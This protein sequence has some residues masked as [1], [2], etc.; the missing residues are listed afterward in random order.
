V[1]YKDSFHALKVLTNLKNWL[2][3][4]G[5]RKLAANVDLFVA[6]L[7]RTIIERGS[8][9]VPIVLLKWKTLPPN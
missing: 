1:I 9:H 5:S 7:H 4:H 8:V 6:I 3:K 2:P